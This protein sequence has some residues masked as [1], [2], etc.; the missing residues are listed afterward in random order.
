M[1]NKMRKQKTR[2]KKRTN[3]TR[4]PGIVGLSTV[5]VG[6]PDR[7]KVTMIYGD[8][9][10]LAPGAGSSNEK[11]YR[12]NSVYDPDY[13]G[14][15]TTAEAFSQLSALYYR[16]R[17]VAS[18]CIVEFMNTGTVPV[19][20]CLASSISN[21]L[22]TTYKVIGF[23]HCATKTICPGGPSNWR[24]SANVTTAAIFGV[25][26]M[27]VLCEDDYAG[28]NTGN[29][30]N[31]WYW[32]LWSN[33]FTGGVAGAITYTLRIEYDVVWSMPLDLSP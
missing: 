4:T 31:V 21:V 25:P 13:T 2:S 27:Q 1:P 15:G 24:H 29:P 17:V 11:H 8:L 3:K 12:G 5:R 28:L 32:H 7:F 6:L 10:T 14:V 30:N 9:G 19:T 18:R 33:N 20:V 26:K 16:Y 23:R 22:P